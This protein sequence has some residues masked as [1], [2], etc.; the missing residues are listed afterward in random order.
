MLSHAADR[1]TPPN[2]DP[3]GDYVP[4]Q[5]PVVMHDPFGDTCL[6]SRPSPCMTRSANHCWAAE[7]GQ[8]LWTLRD[9][10]SVGVMAE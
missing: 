5:P 10:G 9:C 3:F 2:G 4:L 8:C 7:W 1:A 6:C